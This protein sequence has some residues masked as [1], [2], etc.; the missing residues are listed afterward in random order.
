MSDNSINEARIK[1]ALKL[2]HLCWDAAMQDRSTFVNRDRA[3]EVVDS[4]V[5]AVLETLQM[6]ITKPEE[7]DNASSDK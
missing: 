3:M 7:N 6:Y 4:L 2:Q 5:V 1:A